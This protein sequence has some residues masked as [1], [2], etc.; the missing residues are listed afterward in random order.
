MNKTS[1]PNFSCSE[2]CD[3]CQHHGTGR[4]GWPCKDCN[5][6]DTVQDYFEKKRYSFDDWWKNG[7]LE[8]I[9]ALSKAHARLIWENAQE[10]K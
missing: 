9:S 1:S 3:I 7:P 10:N 6:R 2:K 4:G 8:P 5:S